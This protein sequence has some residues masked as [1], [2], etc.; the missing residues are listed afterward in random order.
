[1]KDVL[2]ETLEILM[3]GMID[4]RRCFE[5]PELEHSC[6]TW[7]TEVDHFGKE[8]LQALLYTEVALVQQNYKMH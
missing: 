2:Q 4:G 7:D 3:M 5:D 6:D 8:I 1:M